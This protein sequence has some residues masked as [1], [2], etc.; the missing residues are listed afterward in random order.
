MIVFII[1]SLRYYSLSG[2]RELA[3]TTI[4]TLFDRISSVWDVGKRVPNHSTELEE[5]KYQN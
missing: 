2:N 1:L 5:A 4:D 3:N